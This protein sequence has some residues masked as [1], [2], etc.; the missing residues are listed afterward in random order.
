[1]K[2]LFRLIAT[3]A[4]AVTLC[5]TTAT[6]GNLVIKGST[7]VLPISQLAVEAYMKAH[8]DVN[9]SLIP[10]WGR[11]PCNDFSLC[12]PFVTEKRSG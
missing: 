4:A 7:T 6:A 12:F 8:P 3:V 1:M 5:A 10:R 11:P 9:I 2:K